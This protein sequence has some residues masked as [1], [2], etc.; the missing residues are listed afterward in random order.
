MRDFQSYASCVTQD[1]TMIHDHSKQNEEYNIEVLDH[2]MAI[3][4]RSHV[5]S[6]HLELIDSLNIEKHPTSVISSSFCLKNEVCDSLTHSFEKLYF[7]LVKLRVLFIIYVVRFFK[8]YSSY[9]GKHFNLV[10]LKRGMNS[11]Y[12]INHVNCRH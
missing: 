9:L 7:S 11:P 1:N 10:I 3:M 8:K 12:T 4:S 2:K 6:S 5:I